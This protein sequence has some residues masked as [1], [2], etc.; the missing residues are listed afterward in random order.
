MP[1]YALVQQRTQRGHLSRVVAGNNVLNAIFMVAAS[2]L[3]IVLLG[4]GIT[5]PEL[6][7]IAAILNAVVAVYIYTLVPEFLMRF[8]VWLL[9]HTIYRVRTEGLEQIPNEGPAILVANH[10]SFVD[11]LVIGGSVKRPIRFVMDHHIFKIPV[12]S[13]IFRTA[14]TIPIAS[15]REDPDLLERAFDEIAIA[16]DEGDLVCIFPEG[17]LTDNGEIGDFRSGIERIVKRSPVPVVPM[18][19]QG[20]WDSVFSRQGGRAMSRLPRQLWSR[21]T[22]KSGAPVAPEI[23]QAAALQSTVQKLRGD[24]K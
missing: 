24:S 4:A 15:F 18:A 16:L 8:L 20:L 5:I 12:L 17:R 19:L 7:L 23:A 14:R 9:I 21:V 1:L 13:F 2:L 6:F 3:A 10:V 22:I 11:A